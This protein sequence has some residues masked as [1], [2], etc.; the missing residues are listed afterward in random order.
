MYDLVSGLSAV[1]YG[2]PAGRHY[3][4]TKRVPWKG[5][6]IRS[7]RGEDERIQ[8]KDAWKA[9]S[10]H[11]KGIRCPLSALSSLRFVPI[12]FPRIYSPISVAHHLSSPLFPNVARIVGAK[13]GLMAS[14]EMRQLAEKTIPVAKSV[15][16]RRNRSA[17]FLQFTLPSRI[18]FSLLK[19]QL[20]L[21]HWSHLF[22]SLCDKR[23]SLYKSHM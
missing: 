11:P 7:I 18:L 21:W 1:F 3:R 5:D 13:V 14:Q 6:K 15:R 23:D 16:D 20:F 12:A 9:Y 22:F 4:W 19:T 2:Q 8:E 17:I 10:N